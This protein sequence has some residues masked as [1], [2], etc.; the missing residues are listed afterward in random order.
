M[1]MKDTIENAFDERAALDFS[2]PD[3]VLKDAVLG[4]IDLLDAGEARVAEKTED[5][6][7]VNQ[8]LKKYFAKNPKED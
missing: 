5:S 6:W 3:P 7:K 1:S 8:W 2:R 4:A